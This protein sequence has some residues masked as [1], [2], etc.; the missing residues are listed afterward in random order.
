MMYSAY[1]NFLGFPGGS[2]GKETTCNV[3]SLGLIPGLGGSPGEGSA[4]PLKHSCLRN[5]MDRGARGATV[6]GAAH[7]LV[8]KLLPPPCQV[9]GLL[10]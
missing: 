4:S 10:S 7:S 3:G 9:C 1:I 6:P 8:V 5:T 2:V